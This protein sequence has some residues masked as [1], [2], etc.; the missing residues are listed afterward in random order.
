M[1]KRT[2]LTGSAVEAQTAGKPKQIADELRGLIITGGLDEGDLLGTEADLLER[3]DVSRPSLREALRILEAEG[4]ISVVRGALGGVVV[5]RQRLRAT[6]FRGIRCA[7]CRGDSQ[8]S[9]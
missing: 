4:L 9:E 6:V 2:T 8:R 7:D 5:H 1:A 3:F